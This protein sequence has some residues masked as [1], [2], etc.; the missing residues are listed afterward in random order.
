MGCKEN[1]DGTLVYN[2]Q[3]KMTTDAKKD[4]ERFKL[5]RKEMEAMQQDPDYTFNVTDSFSDASLDLTT[6]PQDLKVVDKSH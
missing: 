5:R 3:Q 2:L 1:F 4:F 6:N